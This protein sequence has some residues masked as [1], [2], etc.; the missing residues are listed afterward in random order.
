MKS[1][2]I[3]SHCFSIST[4]AAL[5]FQV[6]TVSS[7][8]GQMSIRSVDKRLAA[9]NTMWSD[10]AALVASHEFNLYFS[11]NYNIIP[12]RSGSRGLMT[13]I[14]LRRSSVVNRIVARMSSTK[15]RYEV[16]F[17]YFFTTF[18]SPMTNLIFYCNFDHEFCEGN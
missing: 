1:N 10:R 9:E 3:L 11:C 8:E 12:V 16:C 4:T 6:M 13:S 2:K 17:Y 14:G 7:I 18:V 5:P 15:C